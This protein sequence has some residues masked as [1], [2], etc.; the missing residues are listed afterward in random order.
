MSNGLVEG[1]FLCILALLLAGL[2]FVRSHHEA[3][4][5]SPAVFVPIT[6]VGNLSPLLG[7]LVAGGRLAGNRHNAEGLLERLPFVGCVAVAT[8][9]V[10]PGISALGLALAVS[11]TGYWR[12]PPMTMKATRPSCVSR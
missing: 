8:V 6:F 3:Y 10:F 7:G 1:L 2:F 9:G 5:S 11:R 4:W 12:H